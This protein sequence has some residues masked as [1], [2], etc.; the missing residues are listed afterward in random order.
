MPYTDILLQIDS[1]PTATPPAAIESAVRFAKALGARLSALAVQVDIPLAS[2][3]FADRFAHLS[4]LERDWE[5]HSLAGCQAALAH[6]EGV[7]KAA[8]VYAAGGVAR[9]NLYRIDD[10]VARRARTHDLCLVPLSD[11]YDGQL[12]L[13]QQVVFGSGR[14]VLAFPA[15]TPIAA[16][17]RVGDAVVL[18]DGSRA[19]ARAL[20]DALPLLALADSVRVVTFTGEK[21]SARAQA[22]AEVVRHLASHGVAASAA[23]VPAKGAIGGEIDGYLKAHPADLLVMGAYGRPRLI[24]FVLGG[25]T[26]HVLRH[27]PCAVLLS[28]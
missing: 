28:H 9:L 1:F 2:N 4:E 18:W 23:D 11:A 5:Q 3:A 14:P 16:G 27:P 19:S 20:A 13:A 8:G 17:G 7:A 22:G 12:E 15:A 25:A 21:P 10:E 6:F 24:E 26:E